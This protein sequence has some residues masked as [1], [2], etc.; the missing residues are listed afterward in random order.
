MARI[1]VQI[2]RGPT[3]THQNYVGEPGELSVDSDK[4]LLY[5]HDGT[6]PGGHRIGIA[7]EDLDFLDD[8]A[9]VRLS[10]LEAPESTEEHLFVRSDGTWTKVSKSDVGLGSVENLPLASS[11]EAKEG[12]ASNRYMSPQ[13]TTEAIEEIALVTNK[14]TTQALSGGL[15]VRGGLRT[16]ANG[17]QSVWHAGNLSFRLDGDVLT[18]TTG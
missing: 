4:R 7:A 11:A 12:T 8:Q 3:S 5:I 1:I 18:I 2:A 13:R 16:G 6:T 15:D 17:D 9:N 14:T 10:R